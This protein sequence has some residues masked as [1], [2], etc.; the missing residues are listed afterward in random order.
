MGAAKMYGGILS[1]G[2]RYVIANMPTSGYRD[3]LVVAASHPR[4]PTFSSLWKLRDGYAENLGVGSEW[5]YPS[6]VEW[7][8]FLYVV[9]T[10][11]KRHCVMSAIP[12]EALAGE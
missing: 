12:V 8:G 7:D 11:E 4:E 6:A 1:T 10:S 2:Q 3:L 9:Y 5:S